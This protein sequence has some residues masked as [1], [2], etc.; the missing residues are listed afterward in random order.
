MRLG[1]YKNIVV[2]GSNAEVTEAE[3]EQSITNLQRKHSLFYHIDE[4][5]AQAGDV[6]VLN[7]EGF[8][9]GKSF[10]G[11]KATHHRM[12]LGE[13]KFIP[14]FEEQILGHVMGDVFPIDVTFPEHYG[15]VQVAGKDAIFETELVFVGR[16]EIPEFDDD[17]ALDFSSFQ[18]AEELKES[19]VISLQAKKQ[20]SEEERIQEQLL[21]KIIEDSEIPMDEEV[22]AELAEEYMEEKEEE[23]E[24]QGMS[25]ETYLRASHQTIADVEYQC[26]K[27]AR[28]RFAQTAVLHAIALAEGIEASEEELQDALCEAAFY[29][30][31]DPIKFYETLDEEELTGMQLQIL[32]DK[33][34]ELVRT[35]A[36]YI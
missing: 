11:G 22:I 17:F 8:I 14:G 26:R 29:A 33:A 28:R 13:G 19:L 18:T 12:V 23:L 4:R 1:K 34:M 36:E 6:I 7:Y 10:L 2:K 31:M 25:M 32:C 21:T 3:L 30:D 24:L 9:D 20:A 16:E 35:C 5:P 15:N 27:K